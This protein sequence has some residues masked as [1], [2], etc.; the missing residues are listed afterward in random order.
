MAF[1]PCVIQSGS[2]RHNVTV[3]APSVTRDALGQPGASGWTAIRTTRASIEST[4]SQTF[5]FS[6]QNSTLASDSTDMIIMRWTPTPIT[7][8][9]QVVF[10]DQMYTIDDVRNVQQRN[11][12]LHLAC[13]GLGIGST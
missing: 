1:D 4:A 10:G 9:M 5:R 13:T 12:V 8:G 6:F 7:P 11:R 2:L 3:Q